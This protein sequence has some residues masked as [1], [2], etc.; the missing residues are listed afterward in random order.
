M[1]TYVKTS[2]QLYNQLRCKGY[3]NE[4]IA[5]IRKVYDLC[6]QLFTGLYRPSGSTFISHAVGTAGILTDLHSTKELIAAA[7]LHA[8]YEHGDFGIAGTDTDH[9][10]KRKML[11]PY[12]G[13]EVEE[14]IS[15]YTALKW[16][17]QTIELICNN[18]DSLNRVDRNVL[19]IRIANELD[20]NIDLGALY[21]PDAERR[22][23]YI[24]RWGDEITTLAEKL[25]F[26]ELSAELS[27]TFTEILSYAIPSALL[28]N[29]GNV[30]VYRILP[31]SYKRRL[32]IRI[33]NYIN[34]G[35]RRL[36]KLLRSEKHL[37][38]I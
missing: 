2:V 31:F 10:R 25:G 22:K 5:Y 11:K 23:A 1:F 17:S 18:F 13:G 16:N 20:D 21:C 15:K 7:L 33:G 8:A 30:R 35:K 9:H 24:S 36:K 34:M 28:V 32:S 27:R 12:V 29:R 37:R 26:P 3:S 38:D 6:L 19:L 4:D 14:Y